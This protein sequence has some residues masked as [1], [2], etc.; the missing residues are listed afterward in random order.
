MDAVDCSSSCGEMSDSEVRLKDAKGEKNYSILQT[1]KV[2]LFL[3][4]YIYEK[5]AEAK[6]GCSLEAFGIYKHLKALGYIGG[7]CDI[8]WTPKGIKS[9]TIS[10]EC[11]TEKGE[12]IDVCEEESMVVLVENL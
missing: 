10:Y 5:V 3:Y 6:S 7:R 1:A 4:V 9:C 2:H 11:T 12:T 8:P